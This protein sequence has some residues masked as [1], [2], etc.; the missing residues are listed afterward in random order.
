MNLAMMTAGCCCAAYALATQFSMLRLRL[1]AAG[2]VFWY[3]GRRV[4]GFLVIL[5]AGIIWGVGFGFVV[6][7]GG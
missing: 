6:Q 5:W 1:A 7:W 2:F 3:Y 4:W